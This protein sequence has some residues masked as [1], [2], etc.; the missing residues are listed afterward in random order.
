M[1][2][3]GLILTGGGA[4]AA[5]QVG[6]LDG[7]R[8]LLCADGW[9]P[10][11]NPFRVICGTSAGA[12]NAATLAAH[13]D[14]WCAAIE[15]MTR[16]WGDFEP[17]QVYRVDARG[18]IGNAVRWVLGTTFG[19]LVRNKPRSLFDN[20]PL[21]LLLR[22]MIDERK[23]QSALEAG[24]FDALAVTASSYTSGQ[25]VTYFQA[26]NGQSPWFR[27]QRVAVPARIGIKHL[28]A[29]SAIPFIFPAVALQLDGRR[30]FFGDG[31]M[32]QTSPVSP[33][34]HLGSDRVLVIGAAQLQAGTLRAG[35]TGSQYLYPSLAQIAGHA[36]ASI[37]LDALPSDIERVERVNQTVGLIPPAERAKSGLRQVDLLA[38]APSRRLDVIAIPYVKT[39]PRTVRTILRMLGGT[40]RRGSGLA[41]YL[42]FERAYT[43]RL[44]DLGRKDAAARAEQIRKFFAD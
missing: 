38:I 26:R 31:S 10:G 1:G 6:V 5:Y 14:D 33:A 37:F 17:A 36:M 12:I 43:R 20:D 16:V 9:P 27:N 23:L 24:Q 41:S 19:W 13:S 30:E 44:I 18:A 39:L 21:E 8:E 42:L 7:I 4:R 40:G 25:H 3:V 34:I 28:L 29:S 2:K 15:G 22:T 11:R 35:H 32:R